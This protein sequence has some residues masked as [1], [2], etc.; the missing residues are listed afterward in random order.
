MTWRLEQKSSWTSL[1]RTL[2]SYRM[3]MEVTPRGYTRRVWTDPLRAWDY[4][5]TTTPSRHFADALDAMRCNGF[6]AQSALWSVTEPWGYYPYN[7]AAP[8]C[9]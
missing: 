6:I 3:T 4:T 2:A 9:P 8:L 7:A 1:L 5:T